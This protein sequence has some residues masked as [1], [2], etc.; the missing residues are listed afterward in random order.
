MPEFYDLLPLPSRGI[1]YKNTLEVIKINYITTFDQ[2]QLTSPNLINQDNV[3][4]YILTEKINDFNADDLLVQD[5][6][7]I[8]FYL[9]EIAL[10]DKIYYKL[11][12]D[13]ISLDL[14]EVPYKPLEY[15]PNELSYIYTLDN[16][17][18]SFSPMTYGQEK[19]MVKEQST[20]PIISNSI[21]LNYLINDITL[22]G[23]TILTADKLNSVIN[24]FKKI[25]YSEYNKFKSFVNKIL[26]FGYDLN[27]KYVNGDDNIG[28]NI[29]IDSYFFHCSIENCEEY[30]KLLFN[31]ITSLVTDGNYDYSS[32]LSMPSHHRKGNVTSLIKNF[33][34]KETSR[35]KE[36]NKTKK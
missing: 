21:Y 1:F 7:A 30:K 35:K 5:K 18:I 8:L 2:L 12:K 31:E 19:K 29:K 17:L 24:F 26:N 11:N 4:D 16:H 10:G 23:K 22:N 34:D 9:R 20:S 13:E 27:Y 33:E 15:A 3:I 14:G 28:I 32:I 6:N 25:K 36:L